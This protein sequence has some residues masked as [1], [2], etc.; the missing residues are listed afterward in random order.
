MVG[1]AI[2]ACQHPRLAMPT[3]PD[4]AELPEQCDRLRAEA[5][6]IGVLVL[7]GEGDIIGHA[8][9]IAALPDRACEAIGDLFADVVGSVARRELADGDDLVAE[10]DSLQACAAPLGNRA[11]LVLLFDGT[12][13]LA[14]VRHRMK[15]ARDSLLRTLD[16]LES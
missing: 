6:A 16:P 11:V 13:T 14:N 8:G 2:F 5:V 4:S 3:A 9:A 7:A 10:I 12:T 15:H 1:V